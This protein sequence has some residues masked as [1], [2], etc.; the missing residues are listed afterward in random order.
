MKESSDSYEERSSDETNPDVLLTA[1]DGNENENKK[2]NASNLSLDERARQL[3][4]GEGLAPMVRASTTPLRVLA[5]KYGAD[6]VYSEELIDRAIT[7]SN[8]VINTELGTIDYIKNIGEM[9]AKRKRKMSRNGTPLA[10]PVL[11]RI[12]PKIESS[13]FVCQ[14]GTGE[15]GLALQAALHVH[16]DVD[17]IDINMG[18]PKKISVSGVMGS[19]LLS[20]PDRACDIIKTLRRNLSVPVSAKVR[21]LKDTNA[22]LDFCQALIGAGAQAIAVHARRVG[23]EAIHPANWETLREVVTTLKSKHPDLP[24]L[25][26]G[27]FYTRDEWTGIQKE[28]GANGVLLARPALYNASI[29]VKPTATEYNGSYGYDSPLLL[30]R[31]TVVQDY[32]RE[33]LRY[34]VHYKNAK[35]VVCEM[36]SNRRTPTPRIQFM[37]LGLTNARTIGNVCNC[38]SVEEVCKLW[39]VNCD[40]TSNQNLRPVSQHQL[41]GEHVYEDAYFLNDQMH[42]TGIDA[43]VEHPA[44][45]ANVKNA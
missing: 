42:Q 38:Q 6:F 34:G 37:P 39:N 3:Y 19:A 25:V 43:L 20:D 12:D 29:F 17:A 32:L 15:A 30:P 13:K 4:Q 26:N 33:A 21:L 8:R 36:I 2:A 16:A 24:V 18:C 45:R 14:L 40:Q 9:S 5:L 7:N 44:K 35:Y 31:T 23:D 10:A 27:D 22:T 28:T 11:L 41:T 1:D